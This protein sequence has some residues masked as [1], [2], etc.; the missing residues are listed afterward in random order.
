MT[1]GDIYLFHTED[2]GQIS[3]ENGMPIIDGGLETTVYIS[4]FSSL[5][6]WGNDI[7]QTSEQMNSQLETITTRTLT[8][9]ARLDAIEFT[10][11]ALQWMIDDNVAREIQI[12]AT[13]ISVST[14]VIDIMITQPDFTLITTRYELNWDNELNDPV[15]KKKPTRDLCV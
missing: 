1:E 14:L 6:W 12:E 15:F 9:Q 4:L 3:F 10:R 2:G 8:N 5:G 7:S 11:Q 13:I